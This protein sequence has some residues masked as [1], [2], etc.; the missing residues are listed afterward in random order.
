MKL[1]SAWPSVN[2]M[3]HLAVLQGGNAD[4]AGRTL[5]DFVR[6]GILPPSSE[7]GV[8]WSVQ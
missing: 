7:F 6:V 3:L 1:L 4:K 2:K 8:N 5:A